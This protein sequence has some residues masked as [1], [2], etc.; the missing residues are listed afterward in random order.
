MSQKHVNRWLVLLAGFLFNFSFSGTSAFSIFVSPIIEATGWDQGSVYLAYTLYNIMVCL[1]GIVVGAVISKLNIRLLCYGGSILF[2][3]GW[4]ITGFATELWMIYVG[5][6]LIA[7]CGAGALYNFSITTTNKWF[8]DKKGF[9][10]GLLLGGAAIG[11]V[12]CAPVATAI[13]E[14]VGVFSAYKIMGVIYLCLMCAVAW[15]IHVPA[16]DYKPEGWNPPVASSPVAAEGLNWKAMLRTKTFYILYCIFVFACTP[17]MMML[18]CV[19]KIGQE[20]AG[21]TAAQAALSVS[22]LAISNFCGRMFFG[23]VSDKLGR[24][25]TLLIAMC[26]NFVAILTLSQLS[27]TIPFMAVMCIIGACGGALLVMFPPI[28]GEQ[29]GVKHMGLNYSIMF[30]A[31]SIA[32]LVGPQIV[33]KS[34]AATGSY[35]MALII[36]AALTA[37]ACGLL[38]IVMKS[39]KAN[40]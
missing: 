38:L 9:V 17:S 5:F 19:A 4:I 7:G 40:A 1:M 30:S 28:T 2:G 6:G 31:Y 32:S 20:Q 14:S 8:P 12:F 15:M 3:L 35:S 27:A 24:Y 21:M 11:P 26:I 10:S 34:Q 23:T 33:S 25:K 18:G 36:S 22:L 13:L 37:L 29:F 16:P 39:K